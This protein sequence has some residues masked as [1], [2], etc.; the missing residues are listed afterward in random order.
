[1]KCTK[2]GRNAAILDLDLEMD[3]S[4]FLVVFCSDVILGCGV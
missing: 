4:P 2:I 3:E 1:M